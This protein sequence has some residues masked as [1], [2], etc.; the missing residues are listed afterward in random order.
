MDEDS[1][2]EHNIGQAKPPYLTQATFRA[3]TGSAAQ[4]ST[5][6]NLYL[7]DTVTMNCYDTNYQYVINISGQYFTEH[8]NTLQ[9]PSVDYVTKQSIVD[10]KSDKK[11]PV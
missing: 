7:N 8:S 5:L 3:R 2:N 4:D 10:L 6:S 11:A 9:L 1:D